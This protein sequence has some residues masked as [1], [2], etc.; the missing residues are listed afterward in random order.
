MLRGVRGRGIRHNGVMI[1]VG[2]RGMV[3]NERLELFTVSA[4]IVFDLF[5]RIE[6][7]RAAVRVENL[8]EHARVVHEQLVY[9]NL[10]KYGLFLRLLLACRGC[11]V[12]V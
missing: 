3:C 5:D 10:A 4:Q 8:L 2:V 6:L 7:E 12:A 11:K 1:I 9:V